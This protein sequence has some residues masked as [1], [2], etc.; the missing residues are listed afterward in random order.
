M[1]SFKTFVEGYKPTGNPRGKPRKVIP[2]E[3]LDT[4]YSMRAAGLGHKQIYDAT[5]IPHHVMKNHDKDLNNQA[6]LNY[7][8]HPQLST[9]NNVNS[10]RPTEDDYKYL[11]NARKS[12]RSDKSIHLGDKDHEPFGYSPGSI[13]RHF[14]SD[15][16]KQRSD[17]HP[18]NGKTG[19]IPNVKQKPQSYVPDVAFIRAKV[20]G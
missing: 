10:V 14:D 20:Y 2:D 6:R 9:S 8:P 16:A 11:Y 17:Y 19:R 18:P 12:K 3:T 15:E 4:I 13:R 1:K 5:G 7:V